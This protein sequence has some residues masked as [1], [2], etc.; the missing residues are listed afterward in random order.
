MMR[1]MSAALVLVVVGSLAPAQDR[2][3]VARE[4]FDNP[5]D[6]KFLAMAAQCSNSE[7]DLAAI[8]ERRASREDVKEFAKK[9]REEHNN[10]NKTLAKTLKDRKLAIVA[11][12]DK[13]VREEAV[14]LAKIERGEFDA[15]FLK[16]MVESHEKAIKMFENQVKNGKDEEATRFAKDTLPKLKEHLKKAK[17]LQKKS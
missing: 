15:A 10:A 8:A 13:K 12:P 11:V 7:A 2:R 3:P 5:L 9:L 14:R 4:D 17:E 6:A 1:I 16:R